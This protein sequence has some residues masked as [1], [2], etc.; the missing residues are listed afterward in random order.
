M[1][2]IQEKAQNCPRKCDIEGEN[3]NS[4]SLKYYECPKCGLRGASSLSKEGAL[5]NWNQITVKK[6]HRE[7]S[8]ESIDR[9]YFRCIDCKSVNTDDFSVAHSTW[10]EAGLGRGHIHFTCLERR[11]KDLS[12]RS[13]TLSDFP[14]DIPINESIHFGYQLAVEKLKE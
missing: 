3:K 1:E 6:N 10:E 5:K 8:Q 11:L 12:G 7:H 4:S 13:L 2:T 14:P 9:G